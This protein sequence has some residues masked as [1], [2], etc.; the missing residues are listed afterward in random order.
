MSSP[1]ESAPEN[2]DKASVASPYP[3]TAGQPSEPTEPAREVTPESSASSS[4][5]SGEWDEDEDQDDQPGDAKEKDGGEGPSDVGAP[6]TTT[7]GAPPLPSEPLPSDPV[8]QQ[9]DDGWEYHWNANTNSYWFYNRT[10]GVWQQENPRLPTAT[11][12]VAASAADTSNPPPPPGNPTGMSAIG[13]VAGGYNPAIHGD[14]DPNAWYAQASRA[15]EEAAEDAAATVAREAAGELGTGGYFNRATGAW[16][17][18]DQGASRH[19]DEA[20]SRRQLN[21][22]FDVD[23]AA[24]A[25]DGR[26][27]KAERAGKKPSKAELKAFKEK[28]RAKKEEKRRAWLRD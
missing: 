5:E 2:A 21:A 28:R 11:G 27:L 19:S 25:H 23:A 6:E 12:S 24:N 20:K 22:F 1:T 3:E 9:E 13:S 10:T 14:Y 18:E 4:G 17:H 26:S 7:D 15:A 8:G 16:Q